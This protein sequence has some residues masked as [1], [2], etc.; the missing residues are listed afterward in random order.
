[1]QR[2]CCAW[3]LFLRQNGSEQQDTGVT[4]SHGRTDEFATRTGNSTARQRDAENG[5][6][7]LKGKYYVS[8]VNGTECTRSTIMDMRLLRNLLTVTIIP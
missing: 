7:S 6:I 4:S 1:M 5:R 8:P 3:R 2:G